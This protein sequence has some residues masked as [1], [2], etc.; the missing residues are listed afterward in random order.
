MHGSLFWI[1]NEI[2]SSCY[3]AMRAWW[4]ALHS[5]HVFY[6]AT[7][8]AKRALSA[9]QTINES[10]DCYQFQLGFLLPQGLSWLNL[11]QKWRQINVTI[12]LQ[13]VGNCD[14]FIFACISTFMLCICKSMELL[15]WANA[16]CLRG[17]YLD[18]YLLAWRWL[19]FWDGTALWDVCL[20]D[21]FLCVLW[22]TWR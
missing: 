17:V 20:H 6:L 11:F 21:G 12:A 16:I 10:V 1:V 22:H 3:W 14:C 15:L 19:M 4:E 8:Q 2:W 9:I 13:A 7:S 5:F 18:G